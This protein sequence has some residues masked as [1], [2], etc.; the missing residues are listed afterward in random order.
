M[1]TNERT[2][3]EGKAVATVVPTL[4]G[5]VAYKGA[6]AADSRALIPADSPF[7]NL[8]PTKAEVEAMID[9]ARFWTAPEA[10]LLPAAVTPQQVVAM[11]LRGR[12]AGVG[13]T[14]ALQHY[15]I[16]NGRP[17]PDTQLML[18]I[19]MKN[20]P[21]L[22]VTLDGDAQGCRVRLTRARG[23]DIEFKYTI[24]DAT[25]SGQTKVKRYWNKDK[26]AFEDG[27]PGPWQ[28]YPADMLRWA[29]LKRALKVGA[30][31]LTNTIHS[32]L[33]IA[34][35]ERL[36]GGERGDDVLDA[37]AIAQLDEAPDGADGPPADPAPPLVTHAQ[38][39]AAEGE[40][41]AQE[42]DPLPARTHLR[43]MLAEANANAD[44]QWFGAFLQRAAERHPNARTEAG[45]LAID[46]LTGP[47]AVALAAE[48][49]AALYGDG[50]PP[51]SET[52]PGGPQ[53]GQTAQNEPG[54]PNSP[55][56][57]ATAVQGEMV[58]P[59]DGPPPD[60]GAESVDPDDLPFQ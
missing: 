18:A 45:K 56:E 22:K 16:V 23:V 57:P 49:R 48:V 13:P 35:A 6:A 10:K 19:A 9:L 39:A 46:R 60:D 36:L 42:T 44:A 14:T 50:P 30:P 20:D 26:K 31:D 29:A 21:S 28:L 4:P 55:S 5:E 41:A 11:L 25:R 43:A 24:E 54:S 12:E 2:N 51:P 34:E 7:P 47:E 1:A 3:D 17:E 8:M 15:F 33:P 58:E 53:D 32:V 59:G 52:P 40:A 37:I 27:R 38:E